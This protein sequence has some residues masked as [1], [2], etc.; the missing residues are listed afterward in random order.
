MRAATAA[1]AARNSGK[2]RRRNY[3]LG[4][5]SNFPMVDAAQSDMMA[6]Q[7]MLFDVNSPPAQQPRYQHAQ[8]GEPIGFAQ[9]IVGVPTPQWD[10][11]Y[12]MPQMAGF[13]PMQAALGQPAVE[14]SRHPSPFQQL[15]DYSVVREAQQSA[16]MLHERRERNLHIQ[17]FWL[18]HVMIA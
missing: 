13:Q 4:R 10:Q 9:S 2:H 6:S 8:P 7:P 5:R 12:Q 17:D 14:Y 3:N 1:I 11:V 16:S 18:A 15:L